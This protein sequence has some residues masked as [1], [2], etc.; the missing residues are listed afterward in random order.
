[1]EQLLLIN[2]TTEHSFALHIVVNKRTIHCF[3]IHSSLQALSANS[4]E[5]VY[6]V[7]NL[8]AHRIAQV[9]LLL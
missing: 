2:F 8:P 6:C 9:L 4:M 5:R 1:M 3:E 7:G